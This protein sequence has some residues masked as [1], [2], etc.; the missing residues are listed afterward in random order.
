MS[1]W[2]ALLLSALVLL[3]I[4]GLTYRLLARAQAREG[5]KRGQDS[6]EV[7]DAWN[8]GGDDAGGGYGH[9]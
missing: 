9:Q 5:W 2:L 8:A 7:P 6:S 4:F 1:D 3:G